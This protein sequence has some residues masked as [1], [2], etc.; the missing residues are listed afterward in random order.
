MMAGNVLGK[1]YTAGVGMSIGTAF[2]RI[3]GSQAAQA[4]ASYSGVPMQEL[5]SL[6]ET[7]RRDAQP[8]RPADRHPGRII[9]LALSPAPAASRRSEVARQMQ[10]CNACRYCEG[11]CA[12][13]PAMTRRLEF[14]KADVHYLANLCHN[15]GACYARLPVRAAARVRG[16]HSQGHG[17]G[18]A[19]PMPLCLAGALG[20]VSAQRPDRRPGTG[21]PAWRCSCCWRWRQWH[22]GQR[23]TGGNFYAVF[24]HNLLAAMFGAGVRPGAAGAG[25]GVR[26]F[27]REVS[28]GRA[29]GAAAAEAAHNVL[30]LT[31]LGGGHGE[32]CNEADDAYTLLRRR[33]HHFTFY[34]FMLCLAATSVATLY[35]Y[36]L[37][38]RRRIRSGACRCCWARRAASAC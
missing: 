31:Y 29:S 3:A 36:L 14:G 34:G 9:P 32:G 4:A 25:Q 20:A 6:A 19:R 24:P 7:A 5:E 13:F 22:A 35:H 26:R 28:A 38:W 8:G 12:V 2:G 23:P 10:I 30:A 33:F 16:Q 27:W 1:G 17:A 21:R 15:C 18:A 11:F 37:G